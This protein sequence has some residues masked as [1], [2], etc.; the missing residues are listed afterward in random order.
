MNSIF[1]PSD[2][3]DCYVKTPDNNPIEGAKVTARPCEEGEPCDS[4][5]VGKCTTDSDGYCRISG[6][7]SDI[8]YKYKASKE[9]YSCYRCSSILRP[10]Q[11]TTLYLKPKTKPPP[12][13][14][15]YNWMTLVAIAGG[16]GAGIGIL[17][18][19][20]EK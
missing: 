9:G 1:T 7:D 19:L 14:H 13:P 20:F 5:I 15:I 17:A 6:L 2:S 3:I 11:K 12:S 4:R 16:I 8:A 10:G 18:S